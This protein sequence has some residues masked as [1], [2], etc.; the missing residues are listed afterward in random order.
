MATIIKRKGKRGITYRAEVRRSGYP[1]QTRSFDNKQS[2]Q[3]W[4]YNIERDIRDRRVDPKG[5]ADS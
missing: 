5:L 2:A 4:A 3:D 1:N